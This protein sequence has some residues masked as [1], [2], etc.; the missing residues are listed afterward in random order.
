MCR[1][2]RLA[3]YSIDVSLELAAVIVPDSFYN[4]TCSLLSDRVCSAP[5]SGTTRVTVDTPTSEKAL[6]MSQQLLYQV[7]VSTSYHIYNQTKSKA[8]ITL[9]NGLGQGISYDTLQRQLTNQTVSIMQQVEEDMVLI[10]AEMTHNPSTP[11]VF[12]IDN[13]DWVNKILMEVA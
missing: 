8:S 6:L 13:L 7:S 10:P 4:F 2:E 9:N 3:S 11:H 5:L 1:K 12:A